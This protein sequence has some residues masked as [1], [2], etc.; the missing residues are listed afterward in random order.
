M[1]ELFTWQEVASASGGDSM[2][3]WAAGRLGAG[4][5]AWADH[6]AVLVG[7]AGLSLHDR[8]V[9]TGPVA[10]V[11]RLVR[12]AQAELGPAFWP[13][14]DVDLITELADRRPDLRLRTPFGWMATKEHAAPPGD[15]PPSVRWLGPA[16]LPEAAAL[17]ARVYPG[18]YARPGVPGVRRWA[19]IRAP[20]GRLVATGADAWSTPTVGLVSGVVTDPASRG[21]GLGT[22]L[23]EFLLGALL[24]EHGRVALMVDDWNTAA[25]RLYERLGLGHRP[26]V[27]ACPRSQ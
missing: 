22:H 20:D 12:R 4:G 15:P 8:A 9:V 5:R 1:R 16:E 26:V 25:I 17:L 18:S 23:C 14:G 3:V 13:Y 10:A 27:A 6:D 21:A 7:G 2:S 19:G 11:D 24:A